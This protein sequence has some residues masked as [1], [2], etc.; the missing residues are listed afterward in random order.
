M[1]YL[2]QAWKWTEIYGSSYIKDSIIE[3]LPFKWLKTVVQYQGHLFED[4]AKSRQ[5]TLF[6]LC[7][8][9]VSSRMKSAKNLFSLEALLQGL[10]KY[11][12]LKNKGWDSPNGLSD[13]GITSSD[14]VL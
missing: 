3:L 2:C 10:L 8:I 4:V 13:L 6:T 12:T 1:I 11:C 5:P 14:S 7:L 9:P